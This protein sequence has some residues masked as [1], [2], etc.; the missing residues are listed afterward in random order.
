MR[1]QEQARLIKYAPPLNGM[2]NM[3]PNRI[4]SPV[5]AIYSIPDPIL[6]SQ[7]FQLESE[8]VEWSYSVWGNAL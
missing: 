3:S 6:Q 1:A 2:E 8:N 7:R 4:S 5:A